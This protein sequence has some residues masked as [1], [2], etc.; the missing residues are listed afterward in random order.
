MKLFISIAVRGNLDFKALRASQDLQ[1]LGLQRSLAK[2]PSQRSVYRNLPKVTVWRVAARLATRRPRRTGLGA[3]HHPAPSLR[4]PP[5]GWVEVMDNPRTRQVWTDTRVEPGPRHAAPLTAAVQ[6]FEQEAASV[7][8]VPLH[9]PE[10][11]TD[12]IVLDVALEMSDDILQHGFP[13][14]DP[15]L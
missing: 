5:R 7:V 9:T 13:P 14:V 3:L 2:R 15:Q 4:H 10:V 1:I 8:T 11:A 12:A 6:P